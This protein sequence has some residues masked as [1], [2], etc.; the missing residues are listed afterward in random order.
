M[1]LLNCNHLAAT[2]RIKETFSLNDYPIW[3]D[4]IWLID[5]FDAIVQRQG[6]IREGALALC[7]TGSNTSLELAPIFRSRLRY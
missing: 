4:K 7:E 3:Q 2:G 6:L 1:L 5:C